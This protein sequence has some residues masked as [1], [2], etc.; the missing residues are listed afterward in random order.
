MQLDNIIQ[1]V[2]EELGIP[3]E[4]CKEAYKAAWSFI[5][6]KAQSLPL[7]EDLTEAQF[8]EL[9]PNFNLPSLGKLFVT[10]QNYKARKRRFHIIQEL[11]KKYGNDIQDKGDSSDI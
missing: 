4:V 7:K 1:E 5:K 9:R 11:K 8:K 6:E 3:F 2:S 10:E